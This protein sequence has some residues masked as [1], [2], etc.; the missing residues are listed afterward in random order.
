MQ[1]KDFL[2][3]YNKISEECFKKCVYNMTQRHLDSDEQ[4]CINS[5]TQKHVNVNHKT[6]ELFSE[7]NPV[8]QQRKMEEHQAEYAK[9]QASKE[10]NSQP[11][12]Q[13]EI[14]TAAN[15]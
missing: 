1:L 7:I 13:T 14:T 4:T 3:L 15:V 6:M 10:A 5:C 9:L 11:A 8:F 12:N 2:L